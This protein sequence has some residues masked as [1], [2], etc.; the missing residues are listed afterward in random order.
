[1]ELQC[2][3]EYSSSHASIRIGLDA[4]L[5]SLAFAGLQGLRAPGPWNSQGRSRFPLMSFRSPSENSQASSGRNLAARLLARTNCGSSLGVP[6]PTA[7]PHAEQRRSEGRVCLARPACASRF[8]QPL[9]AFIRPTS[10]GLVSCQIR[11]WGSPSRALL[12]SHSLARRL[13]RSCPLAVRTRSRTPPRASSVASAET[14]RL[15]LAP[16]AGR[17]RSAPRL[18]GFAPRESP[19]LQTGCLDRRERV[20]LLGFLPSRVLPL[21]G[22]ATAFTAPPLMRLRRRVAEADLWRPLQGV[23]S[24]RGW[25]VSLETAD[26]P[27]VCRLL[28]TTA[29]GPDAVLG[30]PP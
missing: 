15:E 3:S 20:A 10:A 11:S 5:M 22:M 9:D 13:R 26:P 29:F 17:P 24:A 8:S 23:A 14:P 12:L 1:M 30:S 18:Q 19:P 4:P 2:P 25:L 21:G 7:Y 6:S 16:I 27:G 28:T